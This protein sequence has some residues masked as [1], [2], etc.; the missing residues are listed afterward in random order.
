MAS[1]R[2]LS[3]RRRLCVFCPLADSAPRARALRFRVRAWSWT[4][5]QSR[6]SAATHHRTKT[7]HQYA[8]TRARA[9]SLALCFF[10]HRNPQ[11]V[12]TC[13]RKTLSV[14]S[15]CIKCTRKCD[16]RSLSRRAFG[17]RTK[18]AILFGRGRAQARVVVYLPFFGCLFHS[19]SE[20]RWGRFPGKRFSA[21]VLGRGK[22]TAEVAMRVRNFCAW[23]GE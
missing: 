21:G 9:R 4:T 7:T 20:R 13:A 18:N 15:S 3:R 16:R 12:S 17:C 22:E 8:L 19:A 1:A 23:V 5:H 11:G 10:L 14:S 6:P 2:S